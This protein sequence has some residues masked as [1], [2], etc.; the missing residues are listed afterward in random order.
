MVPSG[1]RAKSVAVGS[2]LTSGRLVSEFLARPRVQ[3]AT[4]HAEILV[5]SGR[6]MAAAAFFLRTT[7]FTS[8]RSGFGRWSL[9]RSGPSATTAAQSRLYSQRSQ[10]QL[11]AHALQPLNTVADAIRGLVDD[12]RSLPA[13][14]R[15]S[16]TR[17]QP[18][19]VLQVRDRSSVQ[20]ARR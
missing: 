3:G 8:G 14:L 12:G 16:R 13:P 20:E 6:R 10:A 1:Q 9:C 2:A 4:G 5:V 17:K 18:L 19:V 7:T 11:D 15:R